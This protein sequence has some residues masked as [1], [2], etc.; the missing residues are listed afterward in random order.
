MPL[1]DTDFSDV[2]DRI[3]VLDVGQYFCTI[4]G[5]E[6]RPPRGEKGLESLNIQL[7]VSE[8]PNQGKVV[9]DEFP[10]PWLKDKSSST[11]VKFGNLLSSAGFPREE[12]RSVATEQLVGKSVQ[13][14]VGHEQYTAKTGD[15]VEKAVV[16]SYIFTK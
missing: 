16:K 2:P 4:K 13:I 5:A 9:F 8:G 10:T 11:A 7:Q 12:R 15:K 6:I 1:L 14:I 3:P